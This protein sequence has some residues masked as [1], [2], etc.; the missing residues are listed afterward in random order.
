MREIVGQK[1]RDARVST[2]V[3]ENI[4]SSGWY[5][6]ENIPQEKNYI[7]VRMVR[8]GTDRKAIN[9]A[10]KINPN[11]ESVIQEVRG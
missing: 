3:I 6:F 7:K 4:G 11:H 2:I 8:C 1:E 10:K 5:R 9:Q